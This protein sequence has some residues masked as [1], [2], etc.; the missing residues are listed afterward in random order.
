MVD[1]RRNFT[2]ISP[3]FTALHLRKIWCPAF[4]PCV[5]VEAGSTSETPQ[6]HP[7]ATFCSTSAAKQQLPSPAALLGRT[8][9]GTAGTAGASSCLGQGDGNRGLHYLII[10]QELET[11]RFMCC[12]EIRKSDKDS[13]TGAA[14]FSE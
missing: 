11:S 12:K 14:L 4:S 6:P 8:C 13:R 5:F 7:Q 2:S 1:K 3:L 10:K 9:V